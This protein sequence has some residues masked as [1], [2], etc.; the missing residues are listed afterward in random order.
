MSV[1]IQLL[2]LAQ[3]A[4]DAVVHAVQHAHRLVHRILAD[5]KSDTSHP[6]ILVCLISCL[7]C[8][9]LCICITHVLLCHFVTLLACLLSRLY[10]LYCF[11]ASSLVCLFVCCRVTTTG[12]HLTI[13]EQLVIDI[14]PCRVSC[15]ADSQ[16]ET[17]NALMPELAT[18]SRRQRR[19]SYAHLVFC[20]V[21]VRTFPVFLLVCISGFSV[22]LF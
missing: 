9:Q 17:D 4:D 3:G 5:I 14:P 18:A 22:H 1:L 12:H 13:T 8:C 10:L 11:V 6:L 21:F 2:T 19:C 15:C 7:L 16:H 20:F